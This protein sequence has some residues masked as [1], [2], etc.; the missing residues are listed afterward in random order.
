ML[1]AHTHLTIAGNQEQ[2]SWPHWHSSE[3][4][5]PACAQ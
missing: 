3:L 5:V 2:S 4:F 1:A